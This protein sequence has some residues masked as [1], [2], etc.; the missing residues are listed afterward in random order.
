MACSG[1]R[2]PAHEPAIDGIEACQLRVPAS[3]SEETKLGLRIN[4]FIMM[5]GGM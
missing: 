5:Y 2:R 3:G 4:V 1:V